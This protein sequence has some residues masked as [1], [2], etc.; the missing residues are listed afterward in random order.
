MLLDDVLKNPTLRR[1]L[2]AGEEQVGKAVGKLLSSATVSGGLQ[3]L[4]QSALHARAAVDRGVQ[5]ALRA[6]HLPSRED[7]AQL[8]RKLDEL[9]SMIDGLSERVG[10]PPEKR[11]DG[12]E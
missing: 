1:V 9:E 12:Q 4:L 7:M 2:A 3:G 11:G 6:A 8:R 10:R 5:Q